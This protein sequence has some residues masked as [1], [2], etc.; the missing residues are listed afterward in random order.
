MLSCCEPISMLSEFELVS[1]EGVFSKIFSNNS[2]FK[3]ANIE[4]DSNKANEND[5]ARILR[6]GKKML[7]KEKKMKNTQLKKMTERDIFIMLHFQFPP[8]FQKSA[9]LLL[10]RERNKKKYVF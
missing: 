8:F 4:P 9:P 3:V 5:S 7:T 2:G 10:S 1:K 6:S